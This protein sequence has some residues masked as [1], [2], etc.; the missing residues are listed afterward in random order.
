MNEILLNYDELSIAILGLKLLQMKTGCG[1]Y[2]TSEFI[3]HS[4]GKM[5]E[6]TNE[7]YERLMKIEAVFI[8]IVEKTKEALTYGGIEFEST[9]KELQSLYKKGLAP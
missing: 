9:E 7:L 8:E 3:N 1:I 4:R 5:F 2:Q 6:R